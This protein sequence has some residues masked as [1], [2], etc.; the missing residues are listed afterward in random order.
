MAGSPFNGVTSKFLMIAVFVGKVPCKVEVVMAWG[1]RSSGGM[2]SFVR[3]G[4]T[5]KESED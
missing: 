2:L 5:T 1:V 4:D 3:I